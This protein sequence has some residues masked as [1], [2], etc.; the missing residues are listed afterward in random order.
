MEKFLNGF[1]VFFFCKLVVGGWVERE[2][3][4]KG[5]KKERKNIN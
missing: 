5:R 1:L 3:N 4:M 2:R